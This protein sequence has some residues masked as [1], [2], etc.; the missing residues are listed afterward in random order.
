MQ[1]REKI[2][3]AM[4]IVAATYGAVDFVLNRQNKTPD[5]QPSL[6][7]STA[8]AELTAQLS[9]LSSPENKKIDQ[10][11]ASIV[12]PWPE[13]CFAFRQPESG[14][15]K[16]VE[17]EKDTT[18]DDLRGRVSQLVYSGFLA[19]GTSRIAIINGMDYRVGDL[20]DGFTVHTI[21]QKAVELRQLGTTFIIQAET[22]PTQKNLPPIAR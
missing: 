15:D 3:I 5:H 22:L 16:Q 11:A 14:K 9:T 7:D 2:I 18:M 19:M 12:V 8:I 17:P 6:S 13:Q 10:L 4:V 21:S 1:K 20:V